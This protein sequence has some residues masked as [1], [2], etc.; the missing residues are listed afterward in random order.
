MIIANQF[1]TDEVILHYCQQRDVDI[2]P[3]QQAVAY[4]TPWVCFMGALWFSLGHQ[5]LKD[6]CYQE[7]AEREMNKLKELL[8]LIQK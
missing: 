6:S 3:W 1:D 7:L 2:E 5:L 8:P 4:W